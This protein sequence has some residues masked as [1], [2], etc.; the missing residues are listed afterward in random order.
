M[1]G[2]FCSFLCSG[3]IMQISGYPQFKKKAPILVNSFEPYYA[4]VHD[5][6][7]VLDACRELFEQL[8]QQFVSMT[9]RFVTSQGGQ[10]RK[11]HAFL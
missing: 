8:G 2:V 7:L 4:M 1:T 9:V 3:E 6:A 11:R 5:V 10:A